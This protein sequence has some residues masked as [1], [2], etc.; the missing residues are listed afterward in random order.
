MLDALIRATDR[1]IVAIV[2]FSLGLLNAPSWPYLAGFLAVGMAIDVAAP[3]L[4][5]S[6]AANRDSPEYNPA[7]AYK[8]GWRW[9]FCLAVAFLVLDYGIVIAATTLSASSPELID[10][11]GRQAFAIASPLSALLR[12]HYETLLGDGYVAR[13][14]L[15]AVA[16]AGQFIVFYATL[17]MAFSI[18]R[19]RFADGTILRKKE[20]IEARK[21]KPWA[22]PVLVVL[23]CILLSF[24]LY[25]VTFPQ[26]DYSDENFRSRHM[27]LNLRD[28]NKFFYDL[29]SFLSFLCLML[30]VTHQF[31]RFMVLERR[32]LRA[33]ERP[34]EKP[35]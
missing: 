25:S 32:W 20:G 13:A 27:N 24:A 33:I 11:M 10:A 23:F 9:L 21:A 31:L 15:V 8:A 16:D 18:N 19:C 35:L 4:L 1:H 14:S 2:F 34:S 3:K 26:I 12:S 28:H 7:L 5:S 30:P 17:A 6:P 29:A 22:M